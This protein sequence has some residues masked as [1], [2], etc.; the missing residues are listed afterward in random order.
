[1]APILLKTSVGTH[2]FKRSVVF[3]DVLVRSDKFAFTTF[4]ILTTSSVQGTQTILPSFKMNAITRKGEND[5]T[6]YIVHAIQSS[7]PL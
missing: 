4:S 6:S 7:S 2:F 3:I 1:M 5:L